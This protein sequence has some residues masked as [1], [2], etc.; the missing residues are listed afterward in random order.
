MSAAADSRRDKLAHPENYCANPKCLWKVVTG[1]GVKPCE[2]HPA[3]PPAKERA[4]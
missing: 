4:S 1:A 3:T 2:K